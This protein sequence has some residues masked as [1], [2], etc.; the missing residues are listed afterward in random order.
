MHMAADVHLISTHNFSL[1]IYYIQGDSLINHKKM[2][3][4]LHVVYLFLLLALPIHDIL[5]LIHTEETYPTK[6]LNA[7]FFIS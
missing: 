5:I 3:S 4:L 1:H 2:A 7:L 6:L